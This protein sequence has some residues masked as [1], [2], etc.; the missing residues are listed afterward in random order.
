M[1]WPRAVLLTW[2]LWTFA[3]NEG[4]W[5]VTPHYPTQQQ[6][7]EVQQAMAQVYHGAWPYTCLPVGETPQE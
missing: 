4:R 2:L 3:A 5:L 1:L 7:V 6:C